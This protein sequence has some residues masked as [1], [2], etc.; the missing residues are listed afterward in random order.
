MSQTARDETVVRPFRAL[1][2][3]TSRVDPA[4]VVSPPYDVIDEAGRQALLA[5]SPYNVVRL[6]LPGPGHEAE[7][8][9]TL[10][11]WIDE[12][13][14]VRES[15]PSA[16]WL[17][18]EATGPDGVRRRR[19]GL[20]ATVRVDAYGTGAVRPH[21]RTLDGP[22]AGRLALMRAVSA[23]LSPIFAI[24]DDPASVVTSLVDEHRDGEPPLIDVRDAD[25]T[26]HRL[27]RIDDEDVLAAIGETLAPLPLVIADGHHRYETAM[28]YRA[29]RRAADG[30]P[31]GE[32]P[33][34]FAPVYLAN[35]RDPGLEPFATHRVIGGVTPEVGGSLRER[36]AADWH[37]EDVPGDVDALERAVS[38]APRDTPAFG[39][40]Q[41]E[42]TGSLLT[43]RDAT[44]AEQALPGASA[45]TRA[46]D[47]A[48][49]GALVL[50]RVLGIDA[51]AV[52]VTDRIRYRRRADEAAALVA[53]EPAGSTLAL[54]LRA[55]TVEQVE[56]VAEA[57]ETMPQK[58]TYFFPKLLDG[59]VFHPLDD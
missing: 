31:D 27:W 25:G 57:G 34:D 12:G 2:Y 39:L 15:R 46:L 37:V 35:R 7:A 20:I 17:E 19:S 22:K 4:D 30:D 58:S 36:L 45:A 26:D 50:G 3:D 47:V 28:T 44:T 21:E 5:R 56:A 29:E 59:L 55:P 52:A 18:Q 51:G 11:R 41:G 24:Y 38:A 9:E 10:A 43:L 54:I 32:R 8:G 53:A 42:G 48:V 49:V 23:N 33:Y 6:I 16:W 14:L 13:I 1:H 40:W